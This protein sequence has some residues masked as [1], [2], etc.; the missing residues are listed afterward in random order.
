MFNARKFT[1]IFVIVFVAA[2]LLDYGIFIAFSLWL[3]GQGLLNLLSQGVYFPLFLFI[4][5]FWA[6]PSLAAYF[7]AL[8]LSFSRLYSRGPGQTK[9]EM[10][11]NKTLRLAIILTI[12]LAIFIIIF[13][14]V[15]LRP[16]QSFYS[17]RSLRE[18]ELE[19]IL[20][21]AANLKFQTY[22]DN[23]LSFEYPADWVVKPDGESLKL[24][25]CD[26]HLIDKETSPLAGVQFG[27]CQATGI[28]PTATI[29]FHRLFNLR[30]KSTLTELNYPNPAIQLSYYENSQNLNVP[31]F[32]WRY[33]TGADGGIWAQT[34]VSR[35]N[36][37]GLTA[38]Y[39]NENYC[40]AVCQTYVWSERGRIYILKN[41]PTGAAS[42]AEIFHRIFQSLKPFG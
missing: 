31:D 36:A 1:G 19:E 32:N 8:K 22:T 41:F 42:Q 38:Y 2:L 27:A 17:L 3:D 30:P 15:V 13:F 34:D 7:I 5:I 23:N 24:E 21:S 9:S 11:E 18:G 33:L 29:V 28:A 39:D 40:V 10:G 25:L 16:Q 20:P 14:C 12:I 26:L 4:W 6:M 35:T 37:N